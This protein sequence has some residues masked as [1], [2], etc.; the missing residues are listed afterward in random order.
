[1]LVWVGEMEGRWLKNGFAEQII[2]IIWE[3]EKAP[4]NEEILRKHGISEQTLSGL[5]FC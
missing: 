3:A 5:Y 4:T 1:M 2:A